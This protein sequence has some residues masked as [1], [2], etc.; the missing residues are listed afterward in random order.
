ME[1]DVI[2]AAS[3]NRASPRTST[4]W[5][6]HRV[7]GHQD[8]RREDG[9]LQ[10]SRRDVRR[11]RRVARLYGWV[12]PKYDHVAVGTHRREQ[13]G[14]QDVP[15]CDAQARR[16]EVRGRRDRPR[17]GAPH[18]R[19]PRPRPR[20]GGVALAGNAAGYV[21]K[22]SGEGTSPPSPAAWRRRRWRSRGTALAVDEGPPLV[23]RQ[24][25][26]QVL[27]HPRCSTSCRRFSPLQPRRGSWRCARTSTCRR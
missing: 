26:P 4:R 27:G 7:P 9:V 23:P 20:Q 14:D 2:G 17:R 21:T 12:F 19:A 22:C 1:V 3:A 16:G 24:V 10:G 13:D 25:G 6:R 11:R 8:P 15:G 18:P 5:C